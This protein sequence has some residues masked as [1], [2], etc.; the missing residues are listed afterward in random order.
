MRRTDHSSR[1]VLPTVERR[2][3]SRNLENEEAKA[4]YRAVK[5]QPQWVVTPGK[6]TRRKPVP[7]PLYPSQIPHGRTGGWIRVSLETDRRLTGWAIVPARGSTARFQRFSRKNAIELITKCSA[8]GR[9][10][11]IFCICCS[12]GELLLD[13]LKVINTA[14]LCLASF[15]NYYPSWHTSGHRFWVKHDTVHSVYKYCN[16]ILR[17][18]TNV[19]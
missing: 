6:R 8:F 14:N 7:V 3:W 17:E 2:V 16:P 18:H 10:G 4:R 1:G 19:L 5:I 9:E 12:T 15:T 11:K 13:L